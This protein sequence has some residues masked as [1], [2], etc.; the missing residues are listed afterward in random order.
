MLLDRRPILAGV[1]L[2]ALCYKPQF[3]LLLPI[4]LAAGGRWRTILSAGATVIA[5]VLLSVAAF[6]VDAW[7]AFL[8]AAPFHRYLL[9]TFH[10]RRITTVFMVVRML[11]GGVGPAYAAQAVSSVLTA[12]LIVAVWAQPCVH[13]VEVLRA[14]RGRVPGDAIRVGLRH[15]HPDVYGDPGSFERPDRADSAPGKN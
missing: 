8:H 14:Y 5:L 6:G 1:L 12:V 13:G 4:A 9:E 3:G 7:T 15:D 11:G 2:G 10:W